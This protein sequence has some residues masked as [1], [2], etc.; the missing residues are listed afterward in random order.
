MDRRADHL[1]AVHT[2]LAV[3]GVSKP[4]S[5]LRYDFQRL[6]DEPQTEDAQ[7]SNSHLRMLGTQGISLIEQLEAYEV[8]LRKIIRLEDGRG[9]SIAQ[10]TLDPYPARFGSSLYDHEPNLASESLS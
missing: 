5:R 7:W 6:I 1:A 3:S 10:M 9:S 8:A 4:H 2:E